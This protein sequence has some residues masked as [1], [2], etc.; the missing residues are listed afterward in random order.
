MG[1]RIYFADGGAFGEPRMSY[2]KFRV[3][4]T[5][6]DNI[7]GSYEVIVKSLQKF[8]LGVGGGRSS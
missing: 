1:V 2:C 5:V 4:R 3:G 7:P 8:E 6:A